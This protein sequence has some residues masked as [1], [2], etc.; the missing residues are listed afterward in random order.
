MT[1]VLPWPPALNHLY[2]MVM[3][4]GSPRMLI[5]ARGRAYKEECGWEAKR[6]GARPQK[7]SL[8]VTMVLYR[9]QKRGDI[10]GFQKAVF[11][12][13]NGIA[14]EDDGQVEELHVYRR[15]DKLRPRVEMTI[16]AVEERTE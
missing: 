11:D 9:P 12:S 7:G 3:V 16:A 8:A 6:Q 14:W 4:K 2:R 10:D 15:D 5:S 1:L 13:V